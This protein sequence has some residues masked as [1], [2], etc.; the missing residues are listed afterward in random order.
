MTAHMPALTKAV[1]CVHCLTFPSC[2][3]VVLCCQ[4][5]LSLLGQLRVMF[6][7]TRQCQWAETC[8]LAT[9]P[10]STCPQLCTSAIPP[11]VLRPLSHSCSLVRWHTVHMGQ[12]TVWQAR[13]RGPRI[14]LHPTPGP[15]PCRTLCAARLLRLVAH[16]SSRHPLRQRCPLLS[17]RHP[18][19]RSRRCPFT[20]RS[21]HVHGRRRAEPSPS[22]LQR[23]P[24]P[25]QPGGQHV[26]RIRLA[27][28]RERILLHAVQAAGRA[29][30]ERAPPRSP[31]G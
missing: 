19:D 23:I 13:S 21:T 8:S 28:V 3:G 7:E 12:R 24:I 14:H 30:D 4:Q 20:L 22:F 18:W 31:G 5:A 11:G 1:I 27:D 15:R 9:A 25:P 6:I 16:S 10:D 2:L 29:L 26:Q 17:L